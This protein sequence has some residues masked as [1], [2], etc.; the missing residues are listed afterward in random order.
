MQAALVGGPSGRIVGEDDFDRVLCYDHL[1]TGGALVIFNKERDLLGIVQR[2]LEFFVEESCGYCTPC[3]VGN[4]LLLERINKIAD[5]LGDESDLE[6]LRSLGRTV[7]ASSRCGLGQTSP[8]PVLS[9]IENFPD[10]YASRIQKRDDL[11]QPGFD[12]H[13]YLTDAVA[14]T[15]RQSVHFEKPEVKS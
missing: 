1:A 12:I 11:Y 8:H 9:T 2:Y 5:G 10:I 4:Q 14:L 6:Y 3:R 7:K 15:G 13:A